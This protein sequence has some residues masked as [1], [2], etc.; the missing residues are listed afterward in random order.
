MG[1][2]FGIADYIEAG[3]ITAVILLNIVVGFIQD[4]RAEKT[5]LSLQQLSAPMCKVARDGQMVSTK[6]ECLVTGDV[7]QLTTG[8]VVPADMRLFDGVNLST[9][10][11]LLTGE[12]FPVVKKPHLVFSSRDMPIGDRSNMV[13]SGSIVTQGRARGVIIASGMM[14]EVGK[15]AK[16]LRDRRPSSQNL[17]FAARMWR[18]VKIGILNILGL[19][20][21]PLQIKLSEFALFLF[22]FA[23]LLATIVFSVN[24]WHV[25]GEVLIYGIC[26]G[27]A[28][29]PESLIAVLTITMAVGT[30]TMARKNVI[31]RKL[32]SLEALNSIGSICS[33]KT[34]TLTQ[35]KMTA[36]MAWIQQAGV[37]TIHNI[38]DP[39][40]PESGTVQANG[41]EIDNEWA[42]NNG[43]LKSFLIA[44]ALCNLS[45]VYEDSGGDLAKERNLPGIPGIWK[46]VGEPTEIALQVLAMRFG[47]GKPSLLQGDDFVFL[48]EHCF[49]SAI[50]RMTVAYWNQNGD[51][52]EVYTKGAVE[53]IIPILS[54]DERAKLEIQD[55]AEKMA[56][57][58][59]R[60][61]CVAK[62]TVSPEDKD[63]V[64]QRSI[65]SNLNFLGL[66]GIFDPPRLETAEAVRQCQMAGI[67]VHMLTG[68]H[69]H[70]ATAIAYEV[71]ILGACKHS[72]RASK[73]VMA[74]DEFDGLS[75]PEID[76]LEALPLVIARCSPSTKVR[77][78]EA[79]HRRNEF[80]V[81][82][83]DGVNDS[84][85]LR[86][87]D[88]GIAMGKSGSGVAK[89]AADIVLADDDFSSIVSAVE[90]GRRLFD[91]IQKFLL[92][93]LVS[94]IAQVILLLVAL[95]FKD[96]DG[97]SV[98]PLSPLEILWVNLITS[99]FLAIGL[100]LEEAQSDLMYRSPHDPRVSVFTRELI[101]DKMI[102]G[103]IMGSLCLVSFVSVIYGTGPG[104]TDLGVDC[105]NGWNDTCQVVFRARATTYATLTFLLLLTAWE[106]KHF[107]RSLFNLDPVRY[108]NW[109]ALSILPALRQNR[110]LFW[111]VVA[112]FSATFPVVYLP[113]INRVVFKHQGITWEWGVVLG[114]VAVY[115]ALVESWKAAKRAFGMTSGGKKIL[116]MQD[117][118]MRAGLS[119]STAGCLSLSA[120]VE[121]KRA[122][123]N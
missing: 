49:D 21:S 102:Y 74:A 105:N 6:T 16:L 90:E 34:G 23:I 44:I 37:I 14:T 109:G 60:V 76:A 95:S 108:S 42:N 59:L 43:P 48:A 46:A 63:Q 84:P 47:Y 107:S 91:N 9:D 20:G 94:N 106:V 4:Y 70:T 121:T 61:L 100:G 8:D 104:A 68:D 123:W 92:H 103:T 41:V 120:S 58:G 69:I 13:Y 122:S 56:K 29:I 87:A 88:V 93:L 35:G 25:Q 78:V 81:M 24:K 18:K 12:S 65:E 15:I 64:F 116:T 113:F 115:L 26:V 2:S 52:I 50:K 7:V 39:F 80:C 117:A 31:V 5:I 77:M 27:V 118:E 96:V 45:A 62:K 114:C 101:I 11:A 40:N 97:N 53:A 66:V 89:E 57:E 17:D 22:A 32:Q 111:A 10:E 72:A 79:L 38:A 3:V 82:T 85:A 67:N 55:Q 86:R 98:F 112:G 110:F 36:R 73:V 83:G 119:P 33:D 99:S 30:K 1:L 28:V 75:D 51:A 71:G 19:T 54:A